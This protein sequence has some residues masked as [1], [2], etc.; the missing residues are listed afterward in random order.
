MGGWI[1]LGVVILVVLW[2][3]FTYNGLITARNRTQEAWS[4]IDVELEPGSVYAASVD[5][6]GKVG[7]NRLEV[8]CAAGTGK[9][10]LAGGID[11]AMKESIQRAFGYLQTNKVKLGIASSFDLTDFHVEAIDLMQN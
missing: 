2:L 11:G 10:K 8:G 1:V 3:V 6:Q 4:E 9:L 7:L 5:D